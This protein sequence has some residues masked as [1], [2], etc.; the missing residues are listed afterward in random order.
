MINAISDF[1]PTTS[2]IIILAIMLILIII[3]SR[4]KKYIK[5]WMI[6]GIILGASIAVATVY[7]NTPPAQEAEP[8]Q[9]YHQQELGQD[10]E[11]EPDPQEF[12][13]EPDPQEFTVK[14]DLDLVG[15]GADSYTA[16]GEPATVNNLAT[17]GAGGP[18]ATLT[19]LLGNLDDRAKADFI[20]TLKREVHVSD[21]DIQRTLD[22]EVDNRVAK[23]ILV[24]NQR[25]SDEQARQIVVEKGLATETEAQAMA[26]VK[27]AGV[28]N[29]YLN[30]NKHIVF[31]EDHRSY[32][33]V[34]ICIMTGNNRA[35]PAIK[36]DCGNILNSIK[37]KIKEKQKE[38]PPQKEKKQPKPKKEK[39]QPKKEQKQPRDPQPTPKKP[40]VA[41]KQVDIKKTFDAP[42][43]V[44]R[45][46][47]IKVGIYV[48]GKQVQVVKLEKSRNY[49]ASVNV[50][51]QKG[52][53]IGFQEL[54]VP[55]H[56]SPSIYI[57]SKQ[58]ANRIVV[59]ITNTYIG[60][61]GQ[62]DDL[63]P[64][65]DNK[66]DYVYPKDKPNNNKIDPTKA[67]EKTPVLEDKD[68]AQPAPTP[69]P[70]EQENINHHNDAVNE[71]APLPG[72]EDAP[73][74]DAAIDEPLNPNSG[75]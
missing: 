56:F 42:N 3:T 74:N 71:A 48:N 29:S 26:V 12:E 58:N 17:N 9:Q 22:L 73:P 47:S 15:L 41:T 18:F 64:K 59:S 2:L 20:E 38:K 54:N 24:N 70:K 11:L 25:I 61:G 4:V 52:Q 44:T 36:T 19:E 65:S 21:A 51:Y 33:T 13:L 7:H 39:K 27:T 49:R 32:T 43:W 6:L 75:N 67:E 37:P 68:K 72:G 50:N 63:K 46:S 16:S 62:H 5:S 34:M 60:G 8:Q 1:I 55:S 28:R 45:P 69:T 31:Y 23:A 14:S 35:V 30:K 53:K 40:E 10:Q 66:N 57:D